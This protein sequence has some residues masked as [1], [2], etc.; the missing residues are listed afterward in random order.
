[1]ERY[2]RAI[3]TFVRLLPIAPDLS[4]AT[5]DGPN[6]VKLFAVPVG[7]CGLE[8][9]EI[10][11]GSR[12]RCD[13][14]GRRCAPGFARRLSSEVPQLILVEVLR[15]GVR[16]GLEC[17][18]RGGLV[19]VQQIPL[20]DIILRFAALVGLGRR[21]ECRRCGST[22]EKKLDRWKWPVRLLEG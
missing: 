4:A 7:S 11:C 13:A 21:R 12:T 19:V 10:A 2:E 8:A 5:P 1:M 17:G 9:F 6:Q 16:C 18:R 3:R 22:P 20:A 15:A 14:V